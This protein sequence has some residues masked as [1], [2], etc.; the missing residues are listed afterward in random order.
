MAHSESS[1]HTISILTFTLFFIKIVDNTQEKTENIVNP[2]YLD[3]MLV[4][5]N[6]VLHIKTLVRQILNALM[7][8]TAVHHINFCI[9]GHRH[10]RIQNNT[11]PSL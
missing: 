8:L 1:I 10:C 5:K 6:V 3:V 2:C 11:L 9:C 7:T 4:T